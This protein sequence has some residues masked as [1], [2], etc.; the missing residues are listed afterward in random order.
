[1][2]SNI[3][4]VCVGNICRSP[5]GA[6]L[7]QSLLPNKTITSAGLAVDKSKLTGKA[8]DATATTVAL[9]NG[10]SLEGHQAQQLTPEMCMQHDLIL[11]MEQGH[12]EALTQIAPEA[13]GKTML[14]GHWLNSNS[15]PDP[16][17]QSREAFEHSYSLI[18]EA[19]QSWANKL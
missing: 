14:F 13:R 17:R 2:F 11:V 8:A 1:M 12:I 5:S 10:I 18:K 4:V 16:Y 19:A 7:L 9:E 3:L 6:K 15:I